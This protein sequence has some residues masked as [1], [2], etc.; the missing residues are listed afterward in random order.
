MEKVK[1]RIFSINQ[2]FALDSRCRHCAIAGNGHHS[3]VEH[4]SEIERAMLPQ[5]DPVNEW[6]GIF[7]SGEGYEQPAKRVKEVA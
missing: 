6:N 3:L 2:P 4:I 7:Q 5:V 1:P